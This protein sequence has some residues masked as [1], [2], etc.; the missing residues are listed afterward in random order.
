[1][2][3]VTWIVGL[4]VI[5]ASALVAYPALFGRRPEPAT[6]EVAARRG[7]RAP[8]QRT[9]P[10]SVD[11]RDVHLPWWRRLR[12]A[13]ALLVVTVALGATL[14]VALAALVLALGLG[15]S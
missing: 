1:M 10:R 11:P 2:M 7:G 9:A 6:V 4:V 14:A 13:G 5:V 15:L 12:S 3:S 8:S